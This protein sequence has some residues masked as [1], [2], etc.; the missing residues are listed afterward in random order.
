MK[1]LSSIRPRLLLLCALCL[2]FLAGCSGKNQAVGIYDL[3]TIV[4]DGTTLEV[5]QLP[6]GEDGSSF[7]VTLDLK[8][9]GTFSLDLSALGD[10]SSMTGVWEEQSGQILLTS[11]SNTLSA[12]WSDGVL[13]LAQDKQTLT[14]QLR[15]E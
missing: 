6:Q 3:K 10:T 4:R 11:G 15:T 13:T 9:D 2:L 5:N 1:N 14:F 8:E 12:A 7:A